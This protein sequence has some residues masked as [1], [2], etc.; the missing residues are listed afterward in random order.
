MTD[1]DLAALLTPRLCEYPGCFTFTRTGTITV[2]AGKPVFGPPAGPVYCSG[3]ALFVAQVRK[4]TG[5][6]DK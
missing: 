5:R 2:T 6:E 3:H 1:H 4:K